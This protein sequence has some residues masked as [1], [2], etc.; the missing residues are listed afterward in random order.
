MRDFSF[1][2]DDTR[3]NMFRRRLYQPVNRFHRNTIEFFF[4]LHEHLQVIIYFIASKMLSS[5]NG[6]R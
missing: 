4:L 2:V 3:R 6:D 1:K 5:S